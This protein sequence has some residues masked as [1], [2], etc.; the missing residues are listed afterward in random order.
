MEVVSHE[1]KNVDGALY[2]RKSIIPFLPL[3]LFA[4]KSP[5]ICMMLLIL[6]RLLLLHCTL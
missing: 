2:A 5:C 1:S 3:K 6:A 4:A